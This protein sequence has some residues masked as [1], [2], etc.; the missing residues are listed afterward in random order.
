M[1]HKAVAAE[2][3]IA[4]RVRFP[5]LPDAVPVSQSEEHL[6][7]ETAAAPKIAVGDVFYGLPW[8]VCPTL[9]LYNEVGVVSED[10]NV[11]EHWPIL[12]RARRITV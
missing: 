7:V 12:A 9:A 4:N 3:P 6:V 8:H 10:G 1:G 2:N 5:A 11:K